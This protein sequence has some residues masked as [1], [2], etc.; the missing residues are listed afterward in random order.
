[1]SGIETNPVPSPAQCLNVAHVN[2]NSVT[3]ESR[4]DELLQF[5]ETNDIK[6]CALTETKLDNNVS[7]SLYRLKGYHDPFTRHRNRNGGGV[8]L[9]AHASITIKRLTDLELEDEKWIWA[10]IKTQNKTI[11][12]CCIYLPPN[13]TASRLELFIER[14]SESICLAQ[15]HVPSVTLILGDFN[16]GNVYLDPTTL[17]HSGITSFDYKL[18]NT[19]DMLNLK[20]LITQPTRLINNINNLRDLIFTD[21]VE[22]ITDSGTL[23]SFS[24]L[25]HFPIFATVLTTVPAQNS[26]MRHKTIWDYTN[27]DSHLLARLLLD[28]DWERILNNDVNVATNQF[29]SV[30]LTAADA[31]IP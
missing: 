5:V 7:Q 17:N 10:K 16:A 20:Q 28:T 22:V 25:D 23:S 29:I 27:I 12:I 1:M 13:L 8:A 15:K 18:K 19:A 6:V 9:Y 24:H 31:S 4:V 11:L 21:N 26:D 14:F 3:A 2:I 30:I